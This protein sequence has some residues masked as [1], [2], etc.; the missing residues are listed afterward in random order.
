MSGSPNDG[1][2]S[3]KRL[4]A[5]VP[6]EAGVEFLILG[7][8]EVWTDGRQV[9]LG[10]PRQ[11]ALLGLLILH[12][13][14]VVSTDRLIDLL[15]GDKPPKTGAAALH[16]RISG[17]RRV[18]EGR[19]ARQ[20][21][22][23]ILMTRAPGY[24]LR[25]EGGRLDADRFETRL[26]EGRR[27]LS[28]G[29]AAGAAAA[30]SAGLSLWRGEPLA[31]LEYEPFAQAEI[32]R[33][34]E[35]RLVAT[36]E[37]IEADLALGRSDQ[38]VAELEGLVA[39]HAVRERLQGQLMLALYRAGR[40]A[41]ALAVFRETRRELRDQLGIDPSPAL[42][43][44]EIAILK[45]DPGLEPL[46]ASFESGAPG[47]PGALIDATERR[48]MVTVVVGEPVI[49][50]GPDLADPESWRSV[51][52]RHLEVATSIV[53]R[54]GGMLG[55][56]SGG[57]LMAVFGVPWIHEDDGMR[58]IRAALDWRAAIAEIAADPALPQVP[59][60]FER[61]GI[62][63]GEVITGD[64]AAGRSLVT[65]EPVTRAS[66][67]AAAAAPGEILVGGAL[68]NLVSGV[69]LEAVRDEAY[70]DVW[71]V[72]ELVS[73]R[74]PAEQRSETPLIGRT[75]ELDQLRQAFERVSH[76][77]TALLC[78]IVGPAGAGKSRL[79]HEFVSGLGERALVLT[80]HCLSYGDGITFWPLSEI[81]GQLAPDGAIERLLYGED[82]PE[83]IARRIAGAIGLADATDG[84]EETFWA[85]RRLIEAIARNGPIVVVLE[86]I[87]WA[88]PTMLALIEHLANWIRESAVLLLC[89]ARPELLEGRPAWGRRRPDAVTVHLEPLG[90]DDS[91]ALLRARPGT[92]GLSSSLRRRV[93]ETAEGN[94]LFLEQIA[95]MVA[96]HGASEGDLPIPPTIEA[97]LVARLDR[98][99]PGERAVLERAAV[100]G[101]EFWP[102]AIARLLPDLA[103]SSVPR[104]LD[105]LVRKDL[106]RPVRSR[107]VGVE[108]FRFRH[109]LI[110]QATYRAIPKTLRRQLH[111]GWGEWLEDQAGAR[112]AEVEELVGYHL[113]QA[114]LGWAEV[115]PGSRR[116][117]SLA[118]RAG[119]RLAASGGRA[120]RRG[121]MAASVNLLD[122]AAALL[123]P[124]D[125]IRLELLSDLAFALFEVGELDR[126]SSVLAAVIDLG[127]AIGDRRLVARA[128]VK[129]SHVEMYR[130]PEQVD[131]ARLLGEA[132]R[133]IAV[134][135]TFGDEAG[136]ARASLLESD[137]LGTLGK[138][139]LAAKAAVRAARF[140]RRAGSRR[141][142]AWSHGAYGY[143]AVFGPDPVAVATRRMEGWLR[144]TGG[145]AVLEANLS[146][147][148]APLAAMEGR[149]GEARERLAHSRVLTD[150]LGLRW[151]TGTHDLLGDGDRHVRD[152]GRHVV[153][154]D[155]FDGAGAGPLRTGPGGRCAVAVRTTRCLARQSAGQP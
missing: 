128:T 17:L 40:Q 27:A 136:L 106:L 70:P 107:L 100:A 37:R 68:R 152:D 38:L 59:P 64:P 145:D 111:E 79:A 83:L 104:H 133:A 139:A 69:V 41:E 72:I 19:G 14:R 26:D 124:D 43:R 63:S 60:F 137:A 81:V 82:Q 74:L 97:V 90:E 62:E 89:L 75:L 109:V 20:G 16:M 6:L 129:R 108:A 24:L 85:V 29:D 39:R 113:E 80:G 138:G 92:S 1:P 67:L 3:R 22:S 123:A 52:E 21:P 105:A 10:G 49:V 28:A 125:P 132:T 122:R 57:Q 91:E 115:E 87:H 120:F 7:P 114:A 9:P 48:K 30:L 54:H 66:H 23:E 110:Q 143:E 51:E 135:R 144:E 8:L 77:R 53:E 58:A 155:R 71:R 94:P 146:G 142:E 78:T 36:E 150:E 126:A 93:R 34:A 32:A 98:L 99:G 11:R 31:D 121:D 5:T 147:F 4:R 15:W 119:E 2:T 50:G 149:I 33:L 116:A 76:N 102:G 44:L 112:L 88:E 140:A 46:F 141:E 73:E 42:Q 96:E 84:V 118:H 131:S 101:K 65:G 47:A 151:Q 25:I 154:L 103:R 134:L 95:A 13:N 12:R 61:I 45:Q 55:R 86:D 35:L 56:R 153:P 130:H 127:T 18:L 148:L 117:E